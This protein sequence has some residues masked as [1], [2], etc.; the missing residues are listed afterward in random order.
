M[1]LAP[2][3]FLC[4]CIQTVEA[5]LSGL[6]AET[7]PLTRPALMRTI[8]LPHIRTSI[9]GAA[10]QATFLAPVQAG[11]QAVMACKNVRSLPGSIRWCCSVY[12]DLGTVGTHCHLL[13]LCVPGVTAQHLCQLLY[14]GCYHAGSSF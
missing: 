3:I 2:P 13:L 12:V 7:H 4:M 5:A 6:I 14:R 8:I 10:D 11:D 9:L 1:M